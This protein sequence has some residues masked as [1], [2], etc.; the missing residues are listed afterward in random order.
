MSK[1]HRQ[2][3]HEEHI[4]ETWLI[5][6]ADLLTL[7]LALFIVLFASSQID[8]KKFEELR[9]SFNA[10][11]QGGK[12]FFENQTPAPS[13]D[14]IGIKTKDM[15]N[16]PDNKKLT[17]DDKKNENQQQSAQQTSQATTQQQA[18]LGQSPL[19]Q[20][21]NQSHLN[22]PNQ[23]SQLTFE[24]KQLQMEQE[25]R[26][27]DQLRK[28]I[29]AYIQENGLTTQLRTELNERELKLVI[30]DHALFASGSAILR[31]DARRLAVVV[32]ELLSKYQ[33]YE[34]VVAGHTD[35]IPIKNALFES[36]WDL[37][38]ARAL[39]FMKVL[40]Q[41]PDVGEKRFSAVGYG[42]Y[43]PVETNDNEAGRS[44]NRRVEVSIIRKFGDTS[45]LP[46]PVRQP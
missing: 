11:F 9:Q 1:K 34:V 43:R 36:N 45:P 5:P 39:S 41:N 31:P 18:Q 40:H 21:K 23:Q 33:Q 29:D 24:Q 46:Q 38:S 26:E 30:S 15:T 35:N 42:E 20:D 44:K 16:S 32:A 13:A 28:Q 12:S 17:S 27:L 8:S 25:R 3:D 7:L 10:A 4:D 19:N 37:S 6:Y 22:D 2:H 14:G